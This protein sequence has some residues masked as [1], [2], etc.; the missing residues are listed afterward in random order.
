M[1]HYTQPLCVRVC[2]TQ[3]FTWVNEST[4][5]RPS[6]FTPSNSSSSFILITRICSTSRYT[7]NNKSSAE[8]TGAAVDTWQVHCSQLLPLAAVPIGQSGQLPTH[9]L[10]LMGKPYCLLYHFLLLQSKKKPVTCVYVTR[11]AS[12]LSF[13]LHS[14]EPNMLSPDAF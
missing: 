4:C 7:H 1:W 8:P 9:F 10:V 11:F 12:A 3:R 14:I 13:A 6:E 5:T 2:V